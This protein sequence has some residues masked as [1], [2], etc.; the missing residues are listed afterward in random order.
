MWSKQLIKLTGA[1]AAQIRK[2]YQTFIVGQKPS[3]Y[4][5]PVIRGPPK[6]RRKKIIE[7]AEVKLFPTKRKR[8]RKRGGAGFIL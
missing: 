6:E 5:N 2:L 3:F 8:R 4:L 7:G 1:S